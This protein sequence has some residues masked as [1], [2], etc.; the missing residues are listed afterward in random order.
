MSLTLVNVTSCLSCRATQ[1]LKFLAFICCC[2]LTVAFSAN[3]NKGG[4]VCVSCLVFSTLKSA[5]YNAFFILAAFKCRIV[6]VRLL[7]CQQ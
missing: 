6:L 4:G 5:L 2:A 1:E 3:L 7:F